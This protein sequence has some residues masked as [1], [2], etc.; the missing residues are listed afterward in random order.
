MIQDIQLTSG[1]TAATGGGCACCTP[2]D[3]AA[4]STRSDALSS[5]GARSSYGV[6][7]MTCGHCVAAVRGELSAL[8]GV[9]DVAVDLVAGGTS[10][11][12]VTTTTPL[13]EAAVAD[14]VGEAGYALAPLPR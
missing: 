6:A 11:V 10:T 4:T 9:T 7:G 13:E 2:A 3:G 8:D 12:T 1:P 5:D 14:A